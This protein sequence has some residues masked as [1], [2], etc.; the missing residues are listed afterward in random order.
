[1]S[2]LEVLAQASANQVD[3]IL[4]ASPRKVREVVFSKLGI[5]SAKNPLAK[6]RQMK[7]QDNKAKL[8][9]EKL[10]NGHGGINLEQLDKL[11][12]ELIRAWLFTKRDLLKAT[13][14]YLKI[15]NDNGL[16]EIELDFFEK[17]SKQE[18]QDLVAYLTAQGF[19]KEHI[20][21]YLNFVKVPHLT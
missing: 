1:V 3:A 18:A 10:R 7:E 8:F 6:L 5:K 21:I 17:L 12:E 20:S 11:C 14:D 13:L 9:Q 2:C 4:Q 19:E 15:P 16:V